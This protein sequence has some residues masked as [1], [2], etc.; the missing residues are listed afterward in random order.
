M[1][2]MK[3]CVL[4]IPFILF[5]VSWGDLLYSDFL[6]KSIAYTT[7][8]QF[9]ISSMEGGVAELNSLVAGE[10]T[11]TPSYFWQ[12]IQQLLG[13]KQTNNPCDRLMKPHYYV[14]P[15][16]NDL[17]K[18]SR[19]FPWRTL[20]YA[21]SQLK[22]GTL[23]IRAGVYKEHVVFTHSG[24]A[25]SYIKIL[26]E[27][28][29]IIDGSFGY[30]DISKGLLTIESASYII[31]DGVTVRNS[32]THGILYTGKGKHIRIRNCRTEHTRGSG[33]YVYGEWP[34]TGY[35][36]SD[37]TIEHNEVHWPQEGAFDGNHIWQEDITLAGGI[38]NFDVSYNYVNA[39]DKVNYHGGPIGID[40]KAGVRNG[41][42]HH[43]TVEN[44]PSNGIYVDA[45]ES[46]AINIKVY[47]N[48][49]KNV[50]GYG[51]PIAGEDGGKLDN[52][53]V[54]NNLIDTSGY[55]GIAFNDYDPKK[56]PD[57]KYYFIQ[58]VKPRTNIKIYNNT[59]YNAGASKGWGW[60][61]MTETQFN[62]QIY[63]NVIANSKPAAMKLK[64]ADISGVTH[65]C[66]HDVKSQSGDTGSHAITTA[67]KFV[68][69]L[70]GDFRLK[71]DSPCIDSGV[72][73]GAPSNDLTGKK[74]PQ[75]KGIDN[76]AYEF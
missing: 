31:L 8:N 19:F 38:E 14:S 48:V 5:L 56:N 25:D 72:S 23:H 18:G 69:P 73:K 20:A 50:T 39:Y 61:I 64:H 75:G 44:I 37:I 57:H 26:G 7:G 76:G 30:D 4:S 65:N 51:I 42:V 43:N 1:T 22:C 45:G 27:K 6:S 11:Q 32:L 36:I 47:Q 3:N 21:A 34:F 10:S 40:V 35:H 68:N 53:E 49:V 71:R 9:T 12:S 58:P 17:S 54:F 74:R 67:P 66:V 29:A 15:T 55:S 59:I 2:K 16:G 60:G 13:E 62:G 24:T 63:N 52:I 28:G 41:V 46:E 33:I 70:K